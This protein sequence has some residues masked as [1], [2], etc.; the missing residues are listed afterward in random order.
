MNEWVG[1][2]GL[3]APTFPDLVAAAAAG[4]I[5]LAAGALA[6]L[7]GRWLGPRIAT[8]WERQAGVHGEGIASRM[9][10]LTRYLTFAALVGLG[11]QSDRWPLPAALLLG[12]PLALAVALAVRELLRGLQMPRWVATLL[13]GIAFIAVVANA[14]GGLAALGAL[15][16][17]IGFTLGSNHFSLLGLVEIGV[18]L[19]ILLA[20]IRLASRFI[21]QSIKRSPRLDATQQLLA[22]KLAGVALLTAAFFLGIDILG[23]DLTALAVFSGALGLAVGFGLQ[24]TF[25]NLIAGIILLMDRSIK[26][27]DVVTVGETFGWVNK[28]GVRAVSVVTRDGQEHLIPNENLMT[29]EVVN[30]SFSSPDVRIHIPVGVAYDC[31]LALAQKLMMEAVTTSPRILAAPEPRVLLR[32][33][34]ER[35]IEHDIRVWIADPAEGVGNIRSEILNRL[36]VLFKE[37]GIE[38]PLPHRD[39]RIREWPGAPEPPRDQ[40]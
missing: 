32:E 14:L 29:Q 17:G 40:G 20:A 4:L 10:D 12:L 28:I 6:I 27:G 7:A 13:A 35:W 8:W 25:G 1:V 34:G 36:W 39:I 38:I 24:K 2:L 22:Q 11:L 16:D 26:P 5:L 3:R 33:F 37:N 23:I 31:D 9:C 30:W 21:N 18:A 15:L 19:L